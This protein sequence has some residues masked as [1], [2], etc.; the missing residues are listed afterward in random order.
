MFVR[1]I[2]I[3]IAVLFFASCSR[4][5]DAFLLKRRYNKGYHFHVSGKHK[6]TETNAVCKS[7]SKIVPK[8]ITPVKLISNSVAIEENKMPEPVA[9]VYANTENVLPF[10]KPRLKP[11][12]DLQIHEAKNNGRKLV[13]ALRK[14]GCG[15]NPEMTNFGGVLAVVMFILL[16]FVYTLAIMAQNPGMVFGVAVVLAALFALLSLATGI[17]FYN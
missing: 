4:K 11:L 3:S 9:V 8:K 17:M 1:I 15:Y 16:T 5:A 12:Q 13:K 6:K 14:G 2:L 10:Q 7:E